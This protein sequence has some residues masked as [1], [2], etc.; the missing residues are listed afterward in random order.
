MIDSP[1]FVPPTP[2]WDV[3]VCLVCGRLTWVDPG[4][5]AMLEQGEAQ[6]VECE[7]CQAGEV[8]PP[9]WSPWRQRT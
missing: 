7:H 2:G 4:G 9:A 1:P 3:L 5:Q 6:G 8:P